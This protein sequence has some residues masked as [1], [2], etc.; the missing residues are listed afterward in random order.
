MPVRRLPR[1]F[2]PLV[3]A[4]L[5]GAPAS[6][7]ATKPS[8]DPSD[9]L[10]AATERLEGELV[11]AHGEVVRE[12]AR[13]G[14]GQ[15]ASYWRPEDG[16]E[17]DFSAFVLEHFAGDQQ[18]LDAVFQRFEFLLEKIRG[19]ARE[20]SVAM[21]WHTDLDL[22]PIL[23]M[24]RVSAAYDPTDHLIEDFFAN[25]LAFMVLLN[26]PL[27]T[28]EERLTEGDEWS[29][30]RW[31][32]A[33]LALG[34]SR[35]IPHSASQAVS[36]ANA[37]A[38]QYIADYNIWMHHVLQP[39]G[40]RLYPAGMRLL[41]HWN[42][43]DQ[44][45]ADYSE[46]REGLERQR[47]VQRVMERIVDQSIPQIV[48]D[49]PAVDWDP[50]S[51]EVSAA[52]VHDSD[53]RLDAAAAVT[54]AP[55]PDTRYAIWLNNFHAQQQV[56]KYSP[57]LPTHIARVFDSGREISEERVTEMFEQVLSSPL[58]K[59]VA[60]LIEARLGR[61]LEPFD[62]WYNGFRP[63]GAYTEAELDAI[64]R[65]RYPT[66]QAYKDDIPRL[67][68]G[69][70]FGAPKAQFLAARIDV[71]PARGSGHAWG[72][73]MRGSNARLRTRVG[74]DG[75]DY[76]GYNIAMHEMGHNVEQVISLENIDFYSLEGVPNNAFT[77]ALA[78]LFQARDMELLGLA[79]PDAD[80]V[81]LQVLDD[82]WSGAEIAAVA[83]VDMG[84]W[85][86]MYDHPRATPAELK[87][88]TLTIARDVWNRFYAPIIGE[89]DVFILA[90]YSHMISNLLY[91]PNY[92]IGAMIQRQIEEQ[93]EK[94]GDLDGEFERMCR[95]GDLTPDLW[96][97]E[98]T[99]KPVG[100]EA[101]LSSAQRALDQVK[102]SAQQ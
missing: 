79:T 90:I 65:E 31:A 32:E 46:G 92:P 42:L 52:Q 85:R 6:A 75:M 2:I 43:R 1:L 45:K 28:L 17:A 87:Q 56:D 72:G 9:W 66:A 68:R 47:T 86:W 38:D 29:R 74:P 35:R 73:A 77:E 101:L 40:S 21:R 25:K 24:D 44:I 93:I 5:C 19:H 102:G 22:G 64:T 12:R 13:G 99:G 78:F 58:M 91:L 4:T 50:R 18:T 97:V 94:A 30:R 41:S 16:D 71:D 53:R 59:E 67:L 39:D 63:R 48:I 57:S 95:L 11:A 34:F 7:R 49:N 96:M 3:A 62:I 23:P 27:T 26:F 51:N 76:K 14:L 98:A 15:V 8:P 20:I 83:L 100:P 36:R 54:N 37:R 70:G 55:E 81:A 89:R 80:S 88:A 60:A 10:P 82:F 61:S 69:L 84:V 33:R